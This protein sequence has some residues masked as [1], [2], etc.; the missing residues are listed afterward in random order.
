VSSS[1]TVYVTGAVLS[2]G[3]VQSDR[4][5]SAFEAVMSAGGFDMNRANLEAVTIIREENGQTRNYTVNLQLVLEGKSTAPFYLK[6][7]DTVY[8]PVKFSLF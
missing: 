3:K 6:R 8:V 2:P 5:I 4:P 1:Y 7:S